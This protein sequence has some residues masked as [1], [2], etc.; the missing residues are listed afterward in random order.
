MKTTMR[1]ITLLLAVA[2]CLPMAVACKKDEPEETEGTSSEVTTETAYDNLPT[3][4]DYGGRTVSIYTWTETVDVDF[5]EDYIGVAINDA[6]YKSRL[7]VEDRLK[8]KFD[9][10]SANGNWDNRNN[11]IS[12]L[13][14][15]VASGE[16]YDVVGQYTPAAPIGAMTGLYKNLNDS[17]Y[18]DFDQPYWPG[19]I[20]DSCSIGENVYFCSGDISATCI[21][22]IGTIFVNL[23]M[24]EEYQITE[25]IYEVVR[26]KEWTMEK[27]KTMFLGSIGTNY[28]ASASEQKYAIMIANR[29]CYDN[30][31][32]GGGLKLVEHD[33][34]N[35]LVMSEDISGSKMEN[36]YTICQDLLWKNDDVTS[37]D[38]TNGLTIENTF[39][40][41][42][43]ILY[44]SQELNDAKNYVKDA[45]F[46]FA[47]VP[48]PMYDE[49][50]Q[51]YC[52]ITGYWVTM[53][54]VPLSAPD[55]DLSEIVLEALGSDAYR[56]ITPVVYEESFQT[57]FLASIDN[58][59]M[60]DIIHASIVYDTGRIFADNISM[61]NIF[62]W[63]FYD[64]VNWKT[65]YAQNSTIWISNIEKVTNQLG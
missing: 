38:G 62:R 32:F 40:A 53:F 42:R 28:G 1:I 23:D 22:A 12:G 33:S 7:N 61:F 59:E 65:K 51:D 57:R 18:L 55:S 50:Q 20:N 2:L 52:S 44:M 16:S 15:V 54:S 43:A 11:F 9:V 64:G 31:F 56:N 39:M 26:N 60:L 24:M 27:M 25:D 10:I 4:L 3:D 8:V 45:D 21:N 41:E 34:E 17:Q 58:G 19:S 37:S 5:A 63:A 48:Y 46:D 14:N 36:W 35:Q 6:T 29:G 13:E 49:N 47:V 30:L